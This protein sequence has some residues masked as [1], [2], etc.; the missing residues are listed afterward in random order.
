[1]LTNKTVL[2]SSSMELAE[3]SVEMEG[4]VEFRGD[5]KSKLMKAVS[6]TEWMYHRGA[7]ERGRQVCGSSSGII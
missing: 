3:G 5:P 7:L 2:A 4:D 6:G 1:M